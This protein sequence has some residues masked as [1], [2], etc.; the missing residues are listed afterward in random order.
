LCDDAEFLR[1]AFLDII[2]T[3]PTP[4]EAR[5]FLADQRPDRRARLVEEL[6]ARPEYADFW[7][8]KWADVLRVERA[9]LGHKKA[10]AFYRWI[11]DSFAENKPQ[12]RF[13][14]ELLT[15][16]GPLS[17]APAGTFFRSVPKPG[18]AASTVS[19]VFLGIRIACA[20]CHHHP[21]DR[22]SQ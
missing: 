7:A 19:Q 20:E 3:L 13:V 4:A 2:G 6:L 15:A 8:L 9:A 5:R 11:R 14:R 1:R 10:Y 22:W 12:D 18:E 16:D 21:F 17:E